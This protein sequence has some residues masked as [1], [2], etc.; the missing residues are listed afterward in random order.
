MENTDR[1]KQYLR[2]KLRRI[3]QLLKRFKIPGAK[4]T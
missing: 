3:N 4:K 2:N 1:N